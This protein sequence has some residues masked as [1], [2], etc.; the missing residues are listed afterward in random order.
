LLYCLRFS[1]ISTVR[2]N[3]REITEKETFAEFTDS[4]KEVARKSYFAQGAFMSFINFTTN[5]SLISVLYV[6]GGL[7]VQGFY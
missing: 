6:G 5:I 4:S 3:S 7:I 1:S 2:L